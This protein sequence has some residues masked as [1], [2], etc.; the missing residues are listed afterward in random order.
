M[1]KAHAAKKDGKRVPVS[2]LGTFMRVSARAL[3]SEQF[4]ILLCI[5]GYF[6]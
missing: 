5:V 2:N 4:G 3:L 1:A 6:T